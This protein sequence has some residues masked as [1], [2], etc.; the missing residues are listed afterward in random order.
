MSS[1]TVNSSSAG[2][3]ATAAG[4]SSNILGAGGDL[5]GLFTT[6]LVAQLKN[7]D[8]TQPSDPSVFV[9]QLAQ[10]SQVQS[11]Q[12]LVSQQQTGNG[13][14]NS[15]QMMAL[16]AQV[17]SAVRAT[18]N[19][20]QLGSQPVT[21]HV[22]LGAN[23]ASN[24]LVL[25]S[26]TGG[27]QQFALGSLAAGDQAFNI[28]PAAL[29][30]APGSYGVQVLDASQ[31]SQPVQAEAALSGVRL[32]QDGSVFAQLAGV[33]EVASSAITALEGRPAT[34]TNTSH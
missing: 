15:L 5:T 18:V 23:S 26:P 8:P 30:L 32:G 31:Q 22:D 14:L 19:Q 25:T 16:G 34:T 10:L 2:V 1:T 17:G 12:Q 11:M 3:A 33:G 13:A 7:Q 27:T 28:D 29:G 21:L 9:S 20:L 24:T 6:L 4:G